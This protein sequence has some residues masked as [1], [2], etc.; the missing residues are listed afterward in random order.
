M[1]QEQKLYSLQFL[2]DGTQISL[3]ELNQK[4]KGTLNQHLQDI[5]IK[6]EPVHSSFLLLTIKGSLEV[7]D[8]SHDLIDKSLIN[9]SKLRF[10]RILDE[11]GDEIRLR[12]YPILAEIEQ[13][14][15][16]F[17]SQS[18]TEVCG[19]DWWD[20]LAPADIRSKVLSICDKH[21]EDGTSLDP[22]E[23]TQ[24]DDLIAI[25]TAEVSEWSEDKSFSVNDFMELLSNCDSISELKNSLKEKMK[26]FSFWNI[27]S[28]FFEDIKEWERTKKSMNF[29]INVRHKV[30]HHRPIRLGVIQA[31]LN[32]KIE[33]LALLDS[34]KSELS[35]QELAKAQEDVKDIQKTVS[36]QSNSQMQPQLSED[37]LFRSSQLAAQL[38]AQLAKINESSISRS[39]ELAKQFSNNSFLESSQLAAQYSR[40]SPFETPQMATQLAKINESSISRSLELAKQFSNNSLLESSQLAAQY[41]R[42]SP[43]E[44]PQM[45]TQLAKINESSLLKTSQLQPQL[46]QI[47]AIIKQTRKQNLQLQAQ[48]DAII[49][50]FRKPRF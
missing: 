43:F 16:V 7:V 24:F 20:N 19:F 29:V 6:I 27:F 50:P 33:I 4:T 3:E 45:A 22:L 30:M 12:A 31:L 23:C 11:A 32:K 15:R 38:L 35:E 26:K 39:L 36:A 41:S 8:V 13:H 46:A 40:I 9:I 28:R 17:I 25:I 49:E 18:L 48:I 5:E 44:T 47:D 14:F 2:F 37:S 42:I 10:K 21:Q 34:A 1:F